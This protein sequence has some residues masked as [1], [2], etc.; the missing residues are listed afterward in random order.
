[1][2]AVGG[3]QAGKQFLLVDGNGDAIYQAGSDY[4]FDIT[5]FAGTLDTGDF[6]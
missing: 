3:D 4:L 5:G 2:F 1:V 6:I